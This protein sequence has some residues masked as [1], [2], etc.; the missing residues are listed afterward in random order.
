MVYSGWQ[1]NYSDKHRRKLFRILAKD[2]P[3]GEEYNPLEEN[4]N[5]RIIEQN[6]KFNKKL[7][8]WMMDYKIQI[9]PNVNINKVND[10]LNESIN[11][12]KKRSSFRDGDKLNIITNP[13]LNNLISTGL[14]TINK[15]GNNI[16]N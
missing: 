7:E 4:D 12:I 11:F 14:K 2:Y 10:I 8:I 1:K 15:R 3:P 9:N 16:L 5:F 6:N 13:I